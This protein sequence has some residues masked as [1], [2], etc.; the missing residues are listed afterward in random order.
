MD[1]RFR[2]ALDAFAVYSILQTSPDQPVAPCLGNVSGNGVSGRIVTV[3][4]AAVAQFGRT[5]ISERISNQ[6]SQA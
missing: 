4:T 6:G 1:R 2:S 5:L 3:L